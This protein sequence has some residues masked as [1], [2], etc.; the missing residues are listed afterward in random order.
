M[1]INIGFRWIRTFI[2]AILAVGLWC[3][4][5]FPVLVEKYYST[6]FYTWFSSILRLLQGYI[7]FSVGDILYAIIII[8]L[9]KKTVTLIILLFNK[10]WNKK[11]FLNGLHK[12]INRLLWLYIIFNIFWGLN[13]DRLGIAYQLKFEP[14]KYDTSSLKQITADLIKKVNAYRLQ[15]RDAQL[16]Y[17]GNKEIFRRTTE[18]YEQV[19]KRFPF[20]RYNNPSI[21]RSLFSEAG[22]YLGY[23]GYYNPLTGEAQ[24][25]VKVPK[26]SIPYITCHE[27]A[28]QLGYASESE[29]NFVGYLAAKSSADKLFNY[30]V[31]FDLF[32][33]ANNELF[34]RDS[35]TARENYKKLDTLVKL[36]IKAYRKY[37]LQY[38][39]Q[40]EPFIRIFYN[41]Y[42][43]ANNQPKGIESYNEIVAWL[44][45]YQKKYGEI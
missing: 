4:S 6:K 44:I 32:N 19:Q 26:F 8:W 25:N 3:F 13:Y 15:V 37:V 5:A 24:V 18:A 2:L 34:Y 7:P 22:N 40:I 45:A 14:A 1:L 23:L 42:L 17:P 10:R 41:N 35:M 33:Y 29:A 16:V 12:T 9:I 21:K 28:H 38:R 27:V 20:L 36:D 30:S 31:Y 43:K 39:N 11:S